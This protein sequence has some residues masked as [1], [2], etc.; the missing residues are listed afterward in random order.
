MTAVSV[1]SSLPT[2]VAV[3]VLPSLKWTL[4]EDAPSTTC[5]AV[6][7][8]PFE[9]Q[10]KPVPSACDCCWPKPKPPLELW[11]TVMSTTPGVTVL[12]SWVRLDTVCVWAAGWT[13][14]VETEVETG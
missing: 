8:S 5:A 9:S 1:E 3:A 12:Y 14:E 6:T 13:V 2:S 4:I 10:T 7:M 11:V